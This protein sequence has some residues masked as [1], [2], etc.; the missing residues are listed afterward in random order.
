[1]QNYF[2]NLLWFLG[3]T[4]NSTIIVPIVY[5]VSSLIDYMNMYW[6]CLFGTQLWPTHTSQATGQLRDPLGRLRCGL[7]R[8]GPAAHGETLRPRAAAAKTGDVSIEGLR[9]P[10]AKDEAGSEGGQQWS[11]WVQHV[12]TRSGIF[13]HMFA[14]LTCWKYEF[15]VVR[16]NKRGWTPQSPTSIIIYTFGWETNE[17]P[18]CPVG[19]VLFSTASCCH[20]MPL[21]DLGE[22]LPEAFCMM[23]TTWM[24]WVLGCPCSA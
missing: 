8:G 9:V 12:G 2:S 17:H 1:M 20:W 14:S 3:V 7:G 16:Q 19:F 22:Q 11:T 18:S 23:E 13:L 21:K 6:L 15:E 5:L 4:Y 24:L 10:G